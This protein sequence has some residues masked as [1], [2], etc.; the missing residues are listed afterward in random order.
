MTFALDQEA[1][2][3]ADQRGK[4][5]D[6]P[7]AYKGTFTR[8][9][10]ITAKTGTAGVSFT[11]LAENGQKCNASLYTIKP[12]GEQLSGY[13][14]IMALLTCLGLRGAEKKIGQVLKWDSERKEE[15]KVDGDIYPDLQGKEIGV[16]LETREFEKRDGSTG[17]AMEIAG[18]FRAKDNFMASE[19]LSRSTHAEQ[20]ERTA[21]SLKHRPLP[22]AGHDN[23]ANAYSQAS[24]GGAYSENPNPFDDDAPF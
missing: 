19:I 24:G 7:G 11:F 3:S 18:F 10:A 21:R 4:W 8:A 2:K 5:I 16:F 23:G 13:K 17:N 15:Y 9:E 20:F 14:Q 22:K 6:L 12:D 1:A